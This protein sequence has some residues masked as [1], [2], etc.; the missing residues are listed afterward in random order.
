MPMTPYFVLN[1]YC[2]YELP[3]LF[4]SFPRLFKFLPTEYA[5]L[6]VQSQVPSFKI[7]EEWEIGFIMKLY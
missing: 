6:Y 2:T 7:G 4:Q 5:L 3:Q 1:L